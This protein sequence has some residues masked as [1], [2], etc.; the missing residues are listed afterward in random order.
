MLTALLLGLD[1]GKNALEIALSE[2]GVAEIVGNKHTRRILDYFDRVGH[3]WVQTDETAWCAAFL[4][5]CLEEANIQS[6]RSLNARSYLDWG[7]AWEDDPQLGCV[8]VFWR[9]SPDSW[10]GHVGFY[11]TERNGWIYVLGGNQ[12]NQVNIQAYPKS[13]LLGYRVP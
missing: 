9:S 2:Y 3:E 11:I 4:G 10:M 8:A 1:H 5:F 6:S 13:R 12:S 7:Q